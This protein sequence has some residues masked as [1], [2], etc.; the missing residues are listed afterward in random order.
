MSTSVL[1]LGKSGSGKSCSVENLPAKNTAIVNVIGKDLPFR[2]SFTPVS[3]STG[4]VFVSDDTTR[5]M[6]FMDHVSTGRPEI[7][8]IVI[9]DSQ[10]TM[11]NHFM[12]EHSTQGKGNGVFALYNDIGDRF[13]NLINK[14]KS[15]RPDLIIYFLH[16][17]EV[18]ETGELKAK[19]IGKMLDD[20]VNIEGMFTICLLA[21]C[22]GGE[23]FFYTKSMGN[24]PTK[25]PKGMF[26]TDKIPNDLAIVSNAIR[27]YYV[28]VPSISTSTTT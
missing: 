11:V 15:L 8:N 2:N 6:A 10:Y 17:S 18:T 28:P 5:I 13:W 4:N 25:T 21:V 22:E 26:D 23:H 16:H 24:T 1:V 12:R 19:S 20:K 14:S 7:K 27:N 9:D 3:G